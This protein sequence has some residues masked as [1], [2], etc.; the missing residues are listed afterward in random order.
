MRIAK[1]KA[2]ITRQRLD[3]ASREV[4]ILHTRIV[5]I[6]VHLVVGT[7]VLA[8]D[9]ALNQDILLDKQSLTSS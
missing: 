1:L 5:H 3:I 9:V 4:V 2:Y 8:D 7:I 6:E